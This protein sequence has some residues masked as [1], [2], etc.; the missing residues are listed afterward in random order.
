MQWTSY[1]GLKK[2]TRVNP[3][4]HLR[5]KNLANGACGPMLPE[6]LDHACFTALSVV[7]RRESV[8]VHGVDIYAAR[9]QQSGY[10]NVVRTSDDMEQRFAVAVSGHYV[11][12]LVHEQLGHG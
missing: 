1:R 10:R 4:V 7:Q 2:W 9:Y 3:P 5:T 6:R 11:R 12:A 8:S